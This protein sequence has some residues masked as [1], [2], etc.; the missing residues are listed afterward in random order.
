[1]MATSFDDYW[2][3]SNDAYVNINYDEPYTDPAYWDDDDYDE[4]ANLF[5]DDEEEAEEEPYPE[6]TDYLKAFV[7]N[8]WS[9]VSDDR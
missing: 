5:D 4:E 6:D 3:E 8:E 2:E 7:A 1:M 9:K